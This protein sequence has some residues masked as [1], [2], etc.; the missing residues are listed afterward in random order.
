MK[1]KVRKK[2]CRHCLYT[3]NHLGDPVCISEIR[4]RAAENPT[5]FKCHEHSEPVICCMWARNKGLGN[6]HT[7][8]PV[9]NYREMI[10]ENGDLKSKFSN[11]TREQ[12]NQY[13]IGGIT[14]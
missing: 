1:K 4:G 14:P 13:T 9:L 3:K 10:S 6:E 7:Q 12:M 5:G 2:P 8:D 11:L